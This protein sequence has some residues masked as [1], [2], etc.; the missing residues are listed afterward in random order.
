[1]K[2]IAKQLNLS[3]DEFKT[4][5]KYLYESG[6]SQPQLAKTFGCHPATIET[7]FHRF[8]IPCRNESGRQRI[9]RGR[10][11]ILNKSE[12]EVLDGLLLSDMHIEQGTFQ[13]RLTF[14]VLH[15]EFANA[16]RDS[17]KSAV[18]GYLYPYK[19]KNSPN[20]NFFCKSAFSIQILDLH[21]HWYREKTKIVPPE[22]TTISPLTLYWWYLGDGY[23]CKDRI[24]IA[25]CTDAFTKSENERLCS[26]LN[27]T[28]NLNLRVDAR[29]RISAYGRD[30]IQQFLGVIGEPKVK[31]YEYK[32][33]V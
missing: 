12:T 18:W 2:S 10:S 9:R 30:N 32:W 22:L 33:G 8:G 14:G 29:N 28:Y 25:L 16:I 21:K 11:V 4:K 17:L 5:L 24:Q 3:D 26:I 23:V 7:Y 20:M 13:G 31:C 1:M 15:K 19:P 27:Q 6:R